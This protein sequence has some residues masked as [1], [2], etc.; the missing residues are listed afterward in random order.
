MVQNSESQEREKE[1]QRNHQQLVEMIATL[2]EELRKPHS[3]PWEASQLPEK[4]LPVSLVWLYSVD[5]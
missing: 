4:L 1:R 2:R 5:A 3:I